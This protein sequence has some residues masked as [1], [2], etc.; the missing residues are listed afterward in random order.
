MDIPAADVTAAI[1]RTPLVRLRPRAGAHV[2]VWAKL[3]AANPGGSAKD[4]TALAM[5]EDA[6]TSGRLAEGG[7]IVES[8]SGNLGLALSMIAAARGLRFTCVVDPRTNEATRVAMTRLGAEVIAV[9]EPD[10]RTGDWLAARLARVERLCA[11]DPAAVW[12]DQYS[13]PAALRAHRDGTMREIV[14]ALDPVDWL[15]VATST[16]GTIGGCLARIRGDGLATRVVAVDAEGSVLFGG[17]RGERRLPGYGAG[18]VPALAEHAAPDEVV[19][20][21]DLAAVAACRALARGEGI[22]AGA[23]SGAVCAALSSRLADIPSGSRVVLI[24]PDGGGAYADNVYSDRWV[25]DT[26]GV[27]GDELERRVREIW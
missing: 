14:T 4:R 13:N 16:T 8:S 6:L 22:L 19:R 10:E 27:G 24:F 15:F 20:V 7:R 3:E 2:D 12:L 21:T 1:G 11:E 23:S 26:L 17:R 9:E 25:A 5:V 18:V